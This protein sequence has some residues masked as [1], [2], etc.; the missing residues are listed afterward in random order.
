VNSVHH[1]EGVRHDNRAENLELWI[2][3]QP[4]GIRVSE[5]IAWAIE[6]I[7]RYVGEGSGAPPTML[8]RAKALLEVAGV[9]PSRSRSRHCRS[10][11]TSPD[12]AGPPVT[13]TDR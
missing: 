8:S 2:K 4:S 12:Q 10:A 5:A 1:R 13:V 7:E 9:E 3:L 11:P 6:I